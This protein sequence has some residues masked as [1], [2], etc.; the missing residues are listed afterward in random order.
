[1]LRKVMS[2]YHV[3]SILYKSP[4]V[5]GGASYGDL[6]IKRH[7]STRFKTLTYRRRGYDGCGATPQ[8]PGGSEEPP[9]RLRTG[10]LSL[11]TDVGDVLCR[12]SGSSNSTICA[13]YNSL[14][15]IFGAQLAKRRTVTLAPQLLSK[16]CRTRYVKNKGQG[17]DLTARG[18]PLL[19]SVKALHYTFG[20]KLCSQTLRSSY[21][22]CLQAPLCFLSPTSHVLY[23][24][25]YRQ[26]QARAAVFIRSS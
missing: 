10:K 17:L 23:I 20:A 7:R 16:P 22:L 18:L 2:V 13:I 3:F 8:G 24:N 21:F 11:A 9:N 1:M 14:A 15:F 5:K 6:P 19:A 12:E 26:I 25:R 4:H